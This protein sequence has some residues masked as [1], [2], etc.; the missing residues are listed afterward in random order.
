MK[1]WQFWTA[2]GSWIEFIF[3]SNVTDIDECSSTN[4][5]NCHG[6]AE[7]INTIGGFNCTCDPGY[8]GDGIT[9]SGKVFVDKISWIK[10]PFT[11]K[12]RFL[13]QN[14]I[15]VVNTCAVNSKPQNGI[16][17]VKLTSWYLIVPC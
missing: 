8:S 3:F 11:G 12:R 16:I 1:Q 17:T 5:N 15:C 10:S 7:C 2:V 14:S 13:M 4:L 9:C 6:N